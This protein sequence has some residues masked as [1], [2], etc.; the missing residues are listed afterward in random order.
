MLLFVLLLGSSFSSF[1]SAEYADLLIPSVIDVDKNEKIS[2]EELYVWYRKLHAAFDEEDFPETFAEVDENTDG[3]ISLSEAQEFTN[4]TFKSSDLELV[5]KIKIRYST[6]IFIHCDRDKDGYLDQDEYEEYLFS[7]RHPSISSVIADKVLLKYDVNNDTVLEYCE[8][9]NCNGQE[10][11]GLKSKAAEFV[12]KFDGDG[13]FVLNKTELLRWVYFDGN[14]EDDI[15]YDVKYVYEVTGFTEGNEIPVDIIAEVM[16]E[17][18]IRLVEPEN[19][20]VVYEDVDT[21]GYFHRDE[22]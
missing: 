8:I 2:T 7:S 3:F 5:E 1:V 11:E 15:V 10:M 19:E 21:E 22:L 12:L 17:I 6:Q 13:D 16:D 9:H 20:E 4:E 14:L 18:D